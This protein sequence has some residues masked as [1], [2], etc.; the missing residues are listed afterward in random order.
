MVIS[1]EKTM[2]SRGRL[3]RVDAIKDSSHN[4]TQ[5]LNKMD[6]LSSF[7]FLEGHNDGKIFHL[8]IFGRRKNLVRSLAYRFY[9]L[10]DSLKK[11]KIRLYIQNH[12]MNPK[13]NFVSEWMVWRSATLCPTIR[14]SAIEDASSALSYRQKARD[15]W[16]HCMKIALSEHIPNKE[17]RLQIDL[18]LRI[19]PL[20]CRIKKR[21]KFYM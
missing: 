4:K 2:T 15:S 9:D 14:S 1:V 5:H 8:R 18:P 6:E 12:L 17:V 10:M 19:W 7:F 3:D 13:K 16:M 11:P 21:T 20:I